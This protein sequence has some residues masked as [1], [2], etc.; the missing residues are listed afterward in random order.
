MAVINCNIKRSVTLHNALHGFRAGR[1]TGTATLE[2]KLAQKLAGI[3][4]EPLS[5]VFLYVQKA[6]D[7]LYRCRCMEILR[8][9]RMG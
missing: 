4:H 3:A 8:G 5:Q 1:G 9:C 7:S 2:E 6:Y